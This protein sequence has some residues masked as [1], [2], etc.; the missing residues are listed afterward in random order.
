MAALP[1]AEGLKLFWTQPFYESTAKNSPCPE[2]LKSFPTCF[3]TPQEMTWWIAPVPATDCSETSKDGVLSKFPVRGNGEGLV[4]TSV[5]IPCWADAVIWCI[6]ESTEKGCNAACISI[7]ICLARCKAKIHQQHRAK[8]LEMLII[9][10][11]HQRDD[12]ITSA[13]LLSRTSWHLSCH[14]SGSRLLLSPPVVILIPKERICSGCALAFLS[15]VHA[16]PTAPPAPSHRSRTWPTAKPWALLALT[17][18][19]S[20]HPHALS[21]PVTLRLGAVLPTQISSGSWFLETKLSHTE[22]CVTWALLKLP[23]TLRTKP[24]EQVDRG[25]SASSLTLKVQTAQPWSNR[26]VARRLVATWLLSLG[27]SQLEASRARPQP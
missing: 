17:P 3:Q 21:M 13:Q 2:S 7:L 16:R 5:K 11:G 18:A 6:A 27:K 15:A 14:L 1:V 23:C 20:L 24:L 10:L 12:L 9:Q 4:P 25:H 19:P 8:L 22:L 26:A